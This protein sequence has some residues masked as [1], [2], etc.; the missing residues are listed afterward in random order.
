MIIGMKMKYI[1]LTIAGLFLIFASGCSSVKNY[2]S[3]PDK[4]FS[5]RVK[6]EDKNVEAEV[7]ILGGLKECE[8]KGDLPAL[9]RV[10][11]QQGETEIGLVPDKLYLLKIYFNTKNFFGDEIANTLQRAL[12]IPKAGKKYRVNLNYAEKMYDVSIFEMDTKNS[13]GKRIPIV[14]YNMCK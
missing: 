5:L 11:L 1:S 6:I 4:N 9:G 3:T 8:G 2:N 12:I 13:V 10:E 14:P 7:Y